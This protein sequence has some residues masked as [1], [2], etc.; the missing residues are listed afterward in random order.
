MNA[1]H[2]AALQERI[3]TKP[4]GQWGPMSRE[5]LRQHMLALIPKASPWP[6][7][8]DDSMIRFYGRPGDESQLVSIP[9]TNIGVKYDGRV[10]RS[11]RCHKRVATALLDSLEEIASGP[12]AWILAQFGGCY[13]DRPM[14]DGTRKSKHAWGAAIDLAPNTNGLR[15]QWPTSA[16]MPIEAMESFAK[17][18]AINLG[19]SIGRDAMHFQFT[20]P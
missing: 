12:A 5:A 10:V 18:G 9:V 11:I 1:K 20:K 19:W 15:S 3:G 13:N 8:D 14:R 2:I 4:D 7:S 6:A 17:R 16:D